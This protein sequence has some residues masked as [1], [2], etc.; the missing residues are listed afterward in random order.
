MAANPKV[1][2]PSVGV[3]STAK[4]QTPL[5]SENSE[6]NGHL[7]KISVFSE[8]SVPVYGLGTADQNY[9]RNQKRTPIAKKS[10]TP[11]VP[12]VLLLS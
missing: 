8:K 4:K 3:S 9:A 2:Q 10:K 11:G 5:G 12:N 1:A 6:S 7:D